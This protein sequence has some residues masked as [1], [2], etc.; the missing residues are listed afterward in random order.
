MTPSIRPEIIEQDNYEMA[1]RLAQEK[2]RQLDPRR[3]AAHAGA[4]LSEEKGRRIVS[5]AF[6]G[7][8]VEVTHPEGRVGRAGEGWVLP[9]WEQILILHYLC[10][11]RPVPVSDRVIAFVELPEG[12]FYDA[13]YQKR[14][15]SRLLKVFGADPER[16]LAAARKLGA[17]PAALG[18]VAVKLRAFPRV[19]LYVALWRGDEEFPPDASVLLGERI[20]GF[21]DAEDTAV[22]ASLVVGRLAKAAG[23]E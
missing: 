11:E 15:K 20:I 6:L 16:L 17:A 2:W 18:D 10:S 4:E 12:R 8:R 14:T 19:D 7:E 22:L 21:L 23:E 5:F 1:L 3:Q 13:A 9:L